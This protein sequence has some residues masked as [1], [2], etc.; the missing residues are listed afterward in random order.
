MRKDFTL[1]RWSPCN[2]IWLFLDVPPQ[3]QWALSFWASLPRSLSLLSMPSM[4]VTSLPHFRVSKRSLIL[5]CSLPISLQTHMSIGS[6][7]IAQISAM[8]LNMKI[9]NLCYLR[10]S[11]HNIQKNARTYNQNQKH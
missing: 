5:C 9:M 3:A 11:T 8:I 1:S 7:H 10:L 6:P 4:I 2:M